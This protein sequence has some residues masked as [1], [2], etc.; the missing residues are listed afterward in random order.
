M[1]RRISRKKYLGGNKKYVLKNNDELIQIFDSP[2]KEYDE[3][4]YYV[5]GNRKK[6]TYEAIKRN[7][8]NKFKDEIIK[9]FDDSK[10]N[11]SILSVIFI[12]K[13]GSNA[14][15]N[16]IIPYSIQSRRTRSRSR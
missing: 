16:G 6:I 3:I 4:I 13:Q 12:K 1:K 9:S 14:V 15:N 5:D 8:T 2:N 10:N 11:A 7:S